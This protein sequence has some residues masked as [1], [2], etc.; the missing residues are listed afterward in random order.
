MVSERKETAVFTLSIEHAIS[1]FPTWK[2]AF[3][4]FAETRAQ[5]GVLGHRIRHPLGD[6]LR[7]VIELDFDT[8]EGAQAFGR[9]LRDVVWSTPDASPA[10]VGTPVA[11]VLV[12]LPYS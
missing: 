2:G 4:R 10:L 5:A 6:P 1:D 7:L 9:F 12:A 3:D 8:A 11:R